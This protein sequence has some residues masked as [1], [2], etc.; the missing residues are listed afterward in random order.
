MPIYMQ[1]AIDVKPFDRGTDVS[2]DG[3][4]FHLPAAVNVTADPPSEAVTLNFTLTGDA[5]HLDIG[6]LVPAVHPTDFLTG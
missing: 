5:L 6:L 2:L 1:R 4:G 3:T